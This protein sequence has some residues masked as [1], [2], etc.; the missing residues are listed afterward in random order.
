MSTS[1]SLHVSSLADSLDAR[2]SGQK[3]AVLSILLRHGFPVPPGV[4]LAAEALDAARA[5]GGPIAP[6]DDVIEHLVAATTALGET[7][8]AV[9]SSGV[10]EDLAGSSYAGLYTT[11]LGVQGRDALAS[12]VQDVW[13]SACSERVISYRPDGTDAPARIAVLIQPMIEARSAGVAFTADPLTGERGVVVIEAIEGLGDALASGEATPEVWEVRGAAAVRRPSDRRVL[14]P[15]EAKAVAE[16]ARNVEVFLGGPHDIEWAIGTSGALLL[17]ARPITALPETPVTPLP[18]PVVVPEGFWEREASHAPLPTMPFDRV[19]WDRRSETLAQMVDQLGL[20]I[21]GIDFRDIGGWEYTR[22]VP[23]GGRDPRPMPQWAVKLA[24][25]LVPELRRRVAK[26]EAAV[27][28]GAAERIVA[29]WFSSWR[30]EMEALVA[31]QRDVDAASLDDHEA[32]ENLRRALAITFRGV[33]VHNLLHG[34]IALA[35]HGLASTCRELLGWADDY[36]IQLLAGLSV[37]STE[38]SRALAELAELSGTADFD[39]AFEDYLRVYGCRGLQYEVAE[40]NLEERPDL[41]LALIDGLRDRGL[42]LEPT[43]AELALRRE[44][45]VAEAHTRLADPAQRQ[46]F[47]DAFEVAVTTYPIREDNEFLTVSAPLGL[48]RRAALDVGRRLA[49]RGAIAT[50]DDVFFLKAEEALDL[51]EHGGSGADTVARRKGERA[52]VLAHP[53]P[54]SYGT[55]PP[56]P[57]LGALP[58]IARRT[59]EAVLWT[60]DRIFGDPSRAVDAGSAAPAGVVCGIGAARGSYTGRVR[61]VLSELDFDRIEPGEVLVCPVTSPVWSVI[62]PRIGALVTDAGGILSHPA[63][64]A[65]EYGIPAV[66]DTK[67]GTTTL[68][69]GQ[70]VTVD[71]DAGL[72]TVAS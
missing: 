54:A 44:A 52:W 71:G 10:D 23:I 11:V 41:I 19:I 15:G 2:A 16:L 29:D 1:T 56:P 50:R 53:G 24:F 45:A 67:V 60:T 58:P 34:P 17:Q 3:A 57:P 38:P 13:Q 72:V 46:R 5:R 40:P 12:A 33:T 61:V 14:T 47:D 6:D 36:S 27:K 68:R 37:R 49:D 18:V 63:I 30:P 59:M 25:R 55:P 28:N 31:E 51:L 9:R 69:D 8:V 7:P 64:I 21:D 35:M 39:L 20:L 42:Q 22:I 66:V 32:A 70:I 43:H 62:F 65:R 4:V 48:C 26:S